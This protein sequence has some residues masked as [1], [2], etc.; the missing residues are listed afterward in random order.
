MNDTLDPD[1]TPWVMSSPVDYTKWNIAKLNQHRHY[2]N[3]RLVELEAPRPFI[4]APIGPEVWG[5]V[6]KRIR[7]EV[8]DL[9]S[10]YFAVMHALYKKGVTDEEE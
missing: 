3:D 5:I 9:H 10:Q 6:P 4:T 2:I 8:K 7:E 1:E